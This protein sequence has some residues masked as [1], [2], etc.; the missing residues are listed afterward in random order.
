MSGPVGTYPPSNLAREHIVRG[1]DHRK[2]ILSKDGRRLIV[3][4]NP[5]DAVLRYRNGDHSV[6]LDEM[7]MSYQIFTDFALAK[8]AAKLDIELSVQT[9]DL[10]LSFF[11]LSGCMV[12]FFFLVVDSGAG[13]VFLASRSMCG[14]TDIAKACEYIISHGEIKNA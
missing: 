12:F 6:K 11:S 3:V 9:T 13:G 1:L 14:T 2:A 4:L 5:N 10:L 7:V 8:H